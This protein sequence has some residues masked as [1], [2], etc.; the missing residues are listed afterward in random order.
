MALALLHLCVARGDEYQLACHQCG[1]SLEIARAEHGA[2]TP[3]ETVAH[4]ITQFSTLYQRPA[5][6]YYSAGIFVPCVLIS[7]F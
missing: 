4:L 6:S 3:L 1:L 5:E 2:S 7:I